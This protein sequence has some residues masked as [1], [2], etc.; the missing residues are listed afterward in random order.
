MVH[1][2]DSGGAAIAL[3]EK[4]DLKLDLLMTDIVMP[5]MNG[6][7]V[8]AKLQPRLPLMKVLYTS[9]YTEDVIAHHGVL[10]KG[11]SFIGK[12]YSPQ[13]LAKKVRQLLDE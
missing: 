2:A 5:T 6:R 8:A 9:G 11:L 10:E 12:P 7:E 13:A 1:D 4:E 3:V